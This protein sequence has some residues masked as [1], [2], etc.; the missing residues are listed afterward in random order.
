MWI[1]KSGENWHC[2]DCNYEFP[3]GQ[4][5]GMVAHVNR[6]SIEKIRK[7]IVSCNILEPEI[8]AKLSPDT[9]RSLLVDL[10]RKQTALK[11][12]RMNEKMGLE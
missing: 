2:L 10:S 12:I 7:I 9:L 4:R 1:E 6:I 3:K 5:A 11:I 8:I